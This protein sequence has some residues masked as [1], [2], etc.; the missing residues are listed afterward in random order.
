MCRG[1]PS[2]FARDRLDVCFA[3]YVTRRETG[4][5]TLIFPDESSSVLFRADTDRIDSCSINRPSAAPQFYAALLD[6]LRTENLVL[7]VPGDCPPLV[8]Q[9]GMVPQVSSEAISAQ[10]APIVLDNA[11]QL[12]SYIERA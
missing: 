12:R 9:V 5:L 2:N 1:Q 8:G 6:L 10:G 4:C 11:E 7:F 3:P